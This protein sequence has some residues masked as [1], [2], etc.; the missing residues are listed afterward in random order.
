MQRFIR[1]ACIYFHHNVRKITDFHTCNNNWQHFVTDA[2]W[3]CCRSWVSAGQVAYTSGVRCPLPSQSM[4]SHGDS[5][6]KHKH[7]HTPADRCCR[8]DPAV[9]S[10]ALTSDK[11][12]AI[13]PRGPDRPQTIKHRR[14][15]STDDSQYFSVQGSPC[16]LLSPP[17][18]ACPGNDF[19]VSLSWDKTTCYACCVSHEPHVNHRSSCLTVQICISKSQI[20]EINN[21]MSQ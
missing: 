10:S 21:F 9:C 12:E 20:R 14:L 5:S 2:G 11:R 8:L 3:R 1:R 4:V 18:F 16:S 17:W 15:S 6:S 19:W 13:K 7:E